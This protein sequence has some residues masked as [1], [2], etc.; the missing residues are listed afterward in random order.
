LYGNYGT[1]SAFDPPT[2]G[3]VSAFDPPTHHTTSVDTD[4]VRQLT[5]HIEKL[6]FY[7]LT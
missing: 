6:Q 2:H 1:V 4:Y 7:W 5:F 3:T